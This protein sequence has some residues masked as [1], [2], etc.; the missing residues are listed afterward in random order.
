MAAPFD[1]NIPAPVFVPP[2]WLPTSRNG[3][4]IIADNRCYYVKRDVE[5]DIEGWAMFEFS[6]QLQCTDSRCK[7]RARIKYNSILDTYTDFYVV[8]NRQHSEDC[9]WNLAGVCVE[10]F[11]NAVYAKLANGTFLNV[12][13]AQAWAAHQFSLFYPNNE[14][15]FDE[16]KYFESKGNKILRRRFPPVPTMA[17]L[18]ITPIPAELTVTKR[19]GG[20]N[21]PFL[22]FRHSFPHPPLPGHDDG[23]IATMIVLG[24]DA[25]FR[26]LCAAP[27]VFADG[28]FKVCPD[29]FYQLY[30]LHKP[31]GNRMRPCLWCLFPRKTGLMYDTFL[32]QFKNLA[33]ARGILIAW[34]VFRCDFEAAVMNSVKTAFPHVS[35]IGCFFH[36]CSA[37]YRKAMELGF[38]VQY[39]DI[40]TSVKTAIKRCMALAFLPSAQIADT[41]D[42]LRAWYG[43]LPQPRVNLDPFFDYVHQSWVLGGVAE[44]A[45]WSIYTLD[46]RRTTNDLEGYHS[47]LSA[48]MGTT[49]S[50]WVFLEKLRAEEEE[51]RRDVVRL[52]AGRIPLQR[53]RYERINTRLRQFKQS[54]D[55]EGTLTPMQYI[56]AVAGLIPH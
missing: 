1:P 30:I 2:A 50:L 14:N 10:Y 52:E 34:I 7:R 47:H 17:T 13:Q 54:Y 40:T 53:R 26:A 19:P 8:N 39:R 4:M 15:D 42:E 36:L 38:S 37:M 9:P 55:V 28:T 51:V 21:Q 11:R 31:Y 35:V 3:R 43:Q 22:L 18:P 29:P 27:T 32:T 24:T 20:H 16:V 49:K 12:K 45:V 25:S 5:F 6:L 41:F 44:P 33:A 48:T 23:G 56:A 46:S